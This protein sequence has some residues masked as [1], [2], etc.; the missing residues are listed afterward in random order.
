LRGQLGLNAV[1]KCYVAFS[2]F[3]HGDSASHFNRGLLPNWLSATKARQS[4][5]FY[6]D[7]WS[8]EESQFYLCE[9]D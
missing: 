5:L 8:P 4:V 9:M 3:Y 2:R 1:G 6:E 7:I